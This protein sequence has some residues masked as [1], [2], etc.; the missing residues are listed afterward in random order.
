[1]SGCLGMSSKEVSRDCKHASLLKSERAFVEP[2]KKIRGHFCTAKN[3]CLSQTERLQGNNF[4]IILNSLQ[5]ANVL[6]NRFLDK[7][8]YNIPNLRGGTLGKTI[9]YQEEIKD[10]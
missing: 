9:C 2:V 1:M 8:R 3:R 4:A 10:A 6:R 5:L 7:C